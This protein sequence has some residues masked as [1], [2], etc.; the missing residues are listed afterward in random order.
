MYWFFFHTQIYRHF[1]GMSFDPGCHIL[2][3]RNSHIGQIPELSIISDGKLF[4]E[5]GVIGKPV[6]NYP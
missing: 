4:I 6:F 3:D 1:S 5:Y 2:V